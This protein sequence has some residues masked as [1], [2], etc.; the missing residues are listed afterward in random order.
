MNKISAF[1]VSDLSDVNTLGH[2]DL[3][4]VS[5]LAGGKFYSRK[6]QIS[7]LYGYIAED[8]IISSAILGSQR[9]IGRAVDEK[10]SAAVA[11]AVA[12]EVSRRLS[13]DFSEAVLRVIS[14]NFN[15]VNDMLD[16]SLDDQQIIDASSETV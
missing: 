2:K 14:A 6:L 12:D 8:P 15:T 9:A 11:L 3:L 16:G 10:I 5:E 1:S 4:M 13:V 7:S